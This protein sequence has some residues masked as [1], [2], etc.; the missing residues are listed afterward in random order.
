MVLGKHSTRIGKD[1][2]ARPVCYQCG[3]CVRWK[4]KVDCFGCG[5][6][7]CLDCA[8]KKFPPS[9]PTTKGICVLCA[10]GIRKY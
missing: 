6:F 9:V 3:K 4:F 1:G 2:I 5:G 10:Y 8:M 7:L